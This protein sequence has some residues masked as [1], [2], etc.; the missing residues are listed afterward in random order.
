MK[1]DKQVQ[2]KIS[3]VK[4]R[5]ATPTGAIAVAALVGIGSFLL[6]RKLMRG[7]PLASAMEAFTLA[8]SAY[9]TMRKMAAH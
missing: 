5:A 7:K 9:G 8:A 1:L 3:A 4:E 2:N 6:S